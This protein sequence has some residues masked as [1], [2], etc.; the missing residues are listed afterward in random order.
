MLEKKNQIIFDLTMRLRSDTLLVV[1]FMQE[2]SEPCKKLVPIF[3]EFPDKYTNVTFM[4]VDIDKCAAVA[5]MC[6]VR[7][8][9]TFVLYRYEKDF[10]RF[11]GTNLTDVEKEIV[12]NYK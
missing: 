7:S 6:E 4:Q 9:P 8:V 3:S 5:E 12:A 1:Y 2:S 11:T 10:F